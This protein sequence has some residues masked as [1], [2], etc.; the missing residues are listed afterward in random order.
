MVEQTLCTSEMITHCRGLLVTHVWHVTA[1]Y[2][3]FRLPPTDPQQLIYVG[4]CFHI[5]WCNTKGVG[6]EEI[7]QTYL[8]SA[9]KKY[10]SNRPF[11]SWDKILVYQCNLHRLLSLKHLLKIFLL[12]PAAVKVCS[13]YL[14]WNFMVTWS[15][16]VVYVSMLLEFV[17]VLWFYSSFFYLVLFIDVEE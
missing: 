10:I 5:V 2:N 6:D 17:F 15:H 11:S 7:L 8:N 3:M 16:M 4:L 13:W 9:S 12:P 1:C 14:A